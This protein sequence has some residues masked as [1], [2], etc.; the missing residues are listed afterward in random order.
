MSIWRLI[1]REITYRRLNFALAAVAVLVA[2]A[3]VVG[4]LT[5]LQAHQVRTE[6]IEAAESEKAGQIGFELK[7]DARRITKDLG[8]NLLI[9]PKDQNLAEFYTSGGHSRTM[10]I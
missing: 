2:V 10:P 1:A 5:L 7:D 4:V 6:R 3:S 8:Y 9:L